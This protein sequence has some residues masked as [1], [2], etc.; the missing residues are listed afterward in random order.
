MLNFKRPLSTTCPP[1]T[2][3]GKLAN[4]IRR[5]LF[6]SRAFQLFTSKVDRL[7]LHPKHAKLLWREGLVQRGCDA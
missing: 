3:I 5:S 6:I 1:L 2:L 7:A 4:R